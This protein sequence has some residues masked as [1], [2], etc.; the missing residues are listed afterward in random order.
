M[1]GGW[2]VNDIGFR[3]QVPSAEEQAPA[4]SERADLRKP[5]RATGW[6]SRR[7]QAPGS[8]DRC[9]YPSGSSATVMKDARLKN[10]VK[11]I[12]ENCSL[13][14]L[15][16]DREVQINFTGDAGEGGRLQVDKEIDVIAIFSFSGKKILLM[17]EC[18]DSK[19]AR[20]VKRYYREY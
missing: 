19:E 3:G 2:D 7:C 15:V 9:Q 16:V 11:T 10:A 14:K 13:D 6:S 12:L 8:G 20:S 18:E 5:V 17:F 4:G 1:L